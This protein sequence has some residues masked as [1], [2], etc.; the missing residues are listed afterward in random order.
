VDVFDNDGDDLTVSFY[1][2]SDDSL[3]D[4][5]IVLGG[6][7]T[8]SVTWSGLSSD[9][10]CIWYV[11]ADDGLNTTQSSTWTFSTTK[12]VVIPPAIPLPGLF[13][14]GLIVMGTT[15]ILSVIIYLRRKKWI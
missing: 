1:N 8:A 14:V 3:I 15:G 5:D 10:I 6:N 12:E 11:I 2:A 9:I 7:G 13:T 4:V